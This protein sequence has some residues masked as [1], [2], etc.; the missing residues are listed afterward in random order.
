MSQ[1]VNISAIHRLVWTALLAALLGVGAIIAVPLGPVSP[2]PVTLQT[3]FVLLCGLVLG[4]RGGIVAILLYLAAGSLGLP[5]FSGG[6]AGIATFMGPTGGYLFSFIAMGWMA[7]IGR[8]N[9]LGVQTRSFWALL[10]VCITASLLNLI[11]G[12]LQLGMLLDLPMT[13]AFG[14]GMVPFLPGGLAK[15]V[16]AVA[17]YRFLAQRRLLPL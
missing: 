10:L 14:V 9:H 1:T 4:P 13:K 15:C 7:G 12:S 11:C 16:A 8:G 3:M 5:V 17:I 6:K 2:V